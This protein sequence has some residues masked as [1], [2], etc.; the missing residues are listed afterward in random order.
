[1]ANVT[2]FG[3]VATTS[4]AVAQSKLE[5]TKNQQSK[6]NN[7]LALDS[8]QFMIDASLYEGITEDQI[9][10]VGIVNDFN[11]LINEQLKAHDTLVQSS[12]NPMNKVYDVQQFIV[13]N[14]GMCGMGMGMG[15]MSSTTVGL[16]GTE[17]LVLAAALSS[18]TG[19]ADNSPAANIMTALGTVDTGF[20]ATKLNDALSNTANTSNPSD[21][22]EVLKAV[23]INATTIAVDVKD[24]NGNSINGACKTGIEI[25]HA[26]GKKT[27]VY[28]ANGNGG[29]DTQ[30]YDFNKSLVNFETDLA[31][32]KNAMDNIDAIKE[33][34]E[35]Q[36]APHDLKI[37]N[38][39]KDGETV[40]DKM[41]LLDKNMDKLSEEAA[42]LETIYDETEN[43]ITNIAEQNA[44]EYAKNC[45]DANVQA[46]ATEAAE[47]AKLARESTNQEDKWLHIGNALKAEIAGR[48][49]KEAADAKK[50]K[51]AEEAKEA[52]EAEEAANNNT[53]QVINNTNVTPAVVTPTP[54]VVTP[55]PA[56]VT[57]APAVVTP[58]PAVVTPAPAVV[59][60][61]APT[62]TTH[63]VKSG[64]TLWAIIT[65][66]YGHCDMNMV[67]QIQAAN[68]FITDVNLIYPGQTIK[69]PNTL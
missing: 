46:A 39:E 20:D 7:Q 60:P 66:K 1:M 45:D 62:S 54:A 31:E 68:T 12:D 11:V 10:E 56:V 58:A 16:S 15:R 19:S 38:L 65:K 14:Q 42:S 17:L 51:E 25:T 44:K 69:L 37:E 5:S 32:Y 23:G 48:T 57:P 27:T 41:S 63:E 33:N 22:V 55:A 53:Q 26:D 59:T 24:E 36:R 49:G 47:E 6:V 28:D 8:N 67:Y 43:V 30:D 13:T 34:L 64:D 29:L 21:L 4:S 18:K 61:A 2:L 40:K 50:I 35:A 9:K 3:G 52:K